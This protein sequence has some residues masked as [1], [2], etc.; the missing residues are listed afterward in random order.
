MHKVCN[1]LF[2]LKVLMNLHCNMNNDSVIEVIDK[3]EIVQF[4][5]EIIQELFVI[6]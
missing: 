6:M 1:F 2:V 4:F 5:L 3:V